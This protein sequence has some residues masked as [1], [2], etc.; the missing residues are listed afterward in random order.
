M[1]EDK[2]KMSG[3]PTRP[4]PTFGRRDTGI[5]HEVELFVPTAPT[6]PQSRKGVKSLDLGSLIPTW[7]LFGGNNSGK[8]TW[9]RWAAGRTSEAGRSVKLAAL[10]KNQRAL[11]TFFSDVDQPESRD[12]LEVA[13]W[14]A[15]FLS[16]IADNKLSAIMDFGGGGEDYIYSVLDD[17]PTLV[18]DLIGAGVGIIAA[19]F[20]T[21]RPDDLQVLA[22]LDARGF[23]P[24]A[25]VLVLNEA[26]VERGASAKDAFA[27]IYGH[28]VFKA[29]VARGAHVVNMPRL[30]PQ[31]LA[32]EIA[33]KRLQ[34]SHA[35]DGTVPEGRTETPIR[36][37]DCSRVKRWL[38]DMEAAHDAV[39]GGLP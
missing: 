12:V 32:L 30:Y 17:G 15:E 36:G 39:K 6:R 29:A 26:H 21:P 1:T 2:L 27:R 37:L 22:A 4:I 24:K 34:F 19:H 11:A 7:M 8:S 25:T 9:A 38:D 13:N 16:Y 18:D 5:E 14:T 10:D 35:R 20:L 28:S 23:K 3:T 31:A 33:T